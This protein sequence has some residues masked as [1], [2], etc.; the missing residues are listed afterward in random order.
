VRPLRTSLVHGSPPEVRETKLAFNHMADHVSQ[1]VAALG[2]EHDELLVE[3]ERLRVTI[4]SIGDGVVVTDAAGQIEFINPRAEELTGFSDEEAR[5]RRLADVL[6][7]YNEHSGAAVVNPLELALQRNV[8]VDMDSHSVIRR[9]D[10][11]MVAISDTAAPIRDSGGRAQ[12]GVMVFQDERERRSLVQRLAWQAERDHLTGLLNRRAM[13]GRLDAALR[14]V[15][16]EARRF[17]FGYIDPDRF[18]LVNDTCGH[19]AGDAL[20]QRLTALLSRRVQDTSHVLA[21]L[22]GD[23]F[24]MLFADISLP[25]A[26]EHIQ[27]VRNEIDRFR[28]EWEDK[29]FRLGV[30]IG[31]TELHAGMADVSDIL[32]Q[33]DTA[34][35]PRLLCD[36]PVRPQPV[37]SGHGGIHPR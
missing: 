7:L 36:Q 3:K 18:K 30:S 1:L 11:T 21:R 27:G 17:I 35:R 4:E 15:R 12:G 28:F 37:R 8:V 24:G 34:R 9:K 6:P 5:G 14:G 22:G 23:E 16:D 31:V 33:A 29:V 32:A 26:L 10:G 19:R 25:Q 20:L 2:R 13:E